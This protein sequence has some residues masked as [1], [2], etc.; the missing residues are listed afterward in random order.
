MA[1]CRV[2]VCV[3]KSTLSESRAIPVPQKI[4]Q[5]ELCHFGAAPGRL[6][7]IPDV[8]QHVGKG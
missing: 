6:A 8:V 7:R 2:C 5:D 3:L 4:S 1:K